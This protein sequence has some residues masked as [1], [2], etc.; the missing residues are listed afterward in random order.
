[1]LQQPQVDVFDIGINRYVVWTAMHY[2][3]AR[4]DRQYLYAAWATHELTEIDGALRI[5]MK[6]VDL[7][8]SDAALGS[9]QL[10]L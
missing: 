5:Q 4:L 9:I 7:V 2:V 1:M 10:F 3:E 8:N 6:R